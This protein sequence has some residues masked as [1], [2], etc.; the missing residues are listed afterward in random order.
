LS[1]VI[2][3]EKEF[4]KQSQRCYNAPD[5]H[6]GPKTQFPWT[7]N[8]IVTKVM[9]QAVPPVTKFVEKVFNVRQVYFLIR[10]E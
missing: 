10:K 4:K 3:I 1:Q 9:N 2:D 8:A 7:Y 6:S 5:L